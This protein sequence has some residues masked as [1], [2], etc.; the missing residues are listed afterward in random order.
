MQADSL[1]QPCYVEVSTAEDIPLFESLGFVRD[2]LA[3]NFMLYGHKVE[4]SSSSNAQCTSARLV[5]DAPVYD[6]LQCM[7]REA[8]AVPQLAPALQ[9]KA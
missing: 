6:S 5:I 4:V 3:A 9:N 1:G 2:E 7:K 8:R